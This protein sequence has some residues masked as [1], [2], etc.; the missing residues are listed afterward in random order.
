MAPTAGLAITLTY[1]S[2]HPRVQLSPLPRLSLDFKRPRQALQQQQQQQQQQQAQAQA[3]ALQQQ[4][5]RWKPTMC[6]ITSGQDLETLAYISGDAGGGDAS[7]PIFLTAS[8]SGAE[9]PATP[10]AASRASSSS[11]PLRPGSPAGSSA[12]CPAALHHQA[13]IDLFYDA[14]SQLAGSSKELPE[15]AAAML[16]ADA[17]ALG[18]EEATAC[19]DYASS[20]LPE[21]CEQLGAHLG[22]A[23]LLQLGSVLGERSC[24]AA[25]RSRGMPPAVGS[26]AA[27]YGTWDTQ[28]FHQGWE[29][30]VH[31]GAEG[32]RYWAWRRPLR[33]GLYMYMTKAGGSRA[34]RPPCHRWRWR[35]RGAAAAGRPAAAAAGA[36][37][38]SLHPPPG[39]RSGGGRTGARDAAVHAGRPAAAVVG[40]LNAGPA[41]AGAWPQ[42]RGAQVLGRGRGRGCAA[43]A[44]RLVACTTSACPPRVCTQGVRCAGGM[45]PAAT[46]RRTTGPRQPSRAARG[47]A[48]RAGSW[49]PNVPPPPSPARRQYRESAFMFSRNKFPTPMASREYVYARRVWNRCAA[50]ALGRAGLAP[51]RAV[52]ASCAR[53]SCRAAA[54]GQRALHRAGPPLQACP[55]HPPTPPPPSCLQGQRRRLLLHLSRLTGCARGA[56]AAG[57]RRAGGRLRVWLRGQERLGAQ[58]PRAGD[59]HGVL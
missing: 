11:G 31:E 26:A 56:A 41:R 33:K 4:L 27:L 13:S 51:R 23:E 42:G 32:L 40:R 10:F 17:A 57:P 49:R 20:V 5:G 6:R 37:R 44:A 45:Q 43:R 34:C 53:S 38:S 12:S 7:C 35:C 8:S 16:A 30:V 21:G 25:L 48:A 28:G 47:S 1:P 55:P 15:A 52:Q 54:W 14:C 19:L 46:A 59:G 29:A 58:R 24:Q 3:Q 22:D 36:A 9:A 39:C 18:D 2:T 50:R